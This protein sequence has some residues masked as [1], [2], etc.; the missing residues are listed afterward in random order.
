[1]KRVDC[2]TI[3]VYHTY[4]SDLTDTDSVSLV[5]AF[6]DLIYSFSTRGSYLAYL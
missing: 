3:K 4:V 2:L 1:M 5:G 6:V